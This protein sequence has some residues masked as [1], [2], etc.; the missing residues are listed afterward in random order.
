MAQEN[1]LRP[2]AHR[3]AAYTAP[4]AAEAATGGGDRD[5]G[6]ARHGAAVGT[7]TRAA[8]AATGT[9]CGKG[10]TGRPGRRPPWRGAGSG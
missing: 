1:K 9:G 7:A 10:S 6:A 4:K 3:G 8:A 2:G 5:R